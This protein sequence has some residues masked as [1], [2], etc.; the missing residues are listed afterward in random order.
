M[1]NKK[2]LMDCDD[3]LLS[4]TQ[5]FRKY[6]ESEHSIIT[7][8]DEP[9]NWNM[10][11]WIGVPPGEVLEKIIDFNENSPKFGELDPINGAV[12]AVRQLHED[13]YDIDIITAVSSQP[14]VHERRVANLMD[15]FGSVFSDV[16]L[17]PV[18]MP[19]LDILKKYD[20][21]IWIEDNYANGLAGLEAGHSVLMRRVAHNRVHEAER[22]TNLCWFDTWSD[23]LDI[24]R[25][26][27]HVMR[28]R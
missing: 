8:S 10:V 13:G 25:M 28:A 4:W 27:R 20:P 21:T 3:V 11:D 26:R 7:T 18:G 22:K 12:D 15:H 24:I 17:V 23:A 19:K 6:L 5:G 1:M 9:D 16:H 2:I 14:H